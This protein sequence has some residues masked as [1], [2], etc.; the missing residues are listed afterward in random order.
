VNF[1]CC[2]SPSA[3]A[4]I[5][6]RAGRGQS[7]LGSKTDHVVGGLARHHHQRIYRD[8][9]IPLDQQAMHGM[10]ANRHARDDFLRNPPAL[11]SHAV[12]CQRRGIHQRQQTQPMQLGT[13]PRPF[14][15]RITA[16]ER[17]RLWAIV[18]DHRL[19]LIWI[20]GPMTRIA[21]Q[22]FQMGRYRSRTSLHCSSLSADTR[23]LVHL[24]APSVQGFHAIN[25]DDVLGRMFASLSDLRTS[26]VLKDK[27]SLLTLDDQEWK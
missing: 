7:E 4:E 10:I 19:W 2:G 12:R 20:D 5:L 22:Q 9:V 13:D 26:D 17:R 14:F 25:Y 16:H 21:S 15:G 18:R 6:L 3:P 24:Q 23:L 27:L 8:R 1:P 11:I